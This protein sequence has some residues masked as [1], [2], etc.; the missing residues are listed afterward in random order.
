VSPYCNTASA[1]TA[2]NPTSLKID[3]AYAIYLLDGTSPEGFS[4]NQV[5]P[6]W[7]LAD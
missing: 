7:T 3:V 4:A 6:R 5:P 2:K 1:G